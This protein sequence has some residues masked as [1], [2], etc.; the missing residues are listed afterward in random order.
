MLDRDLAVG[1]QQLELRGLRG[2]YHE[3]FLPLFG[4]HQAGNAAC[5]LAAVE[6]FAGAGDDDAAGAQPSRSTR[7]GSATRSRR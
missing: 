2:D 6:A 1:G 3:V 7:P 5:A 4:A